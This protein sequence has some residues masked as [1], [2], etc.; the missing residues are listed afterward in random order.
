M[1]FGRLEFKHFALRSEINLLKSSPHYA[2]SNGLSEKAVGT[3]KGL[4]KKCKG[5]H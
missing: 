3:V 1:P 2:A 4:F 5:W